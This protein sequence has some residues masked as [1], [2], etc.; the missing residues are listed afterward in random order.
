LEGSGRHRL[1]GEQG[2]DLGWLAALEDFEPC[3]FQPS[4]RGRVDDAAASDGLGRA[5]NET[6]ASR[7][8][9]RLLETQLGKPAGANEPGRDVGGSEMHLDRRRHRLELVQH[10]VEAI[11]D[12]V[13]TWLN[14]RVA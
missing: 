6:V 13:T 11:A 3:G 10:D 9:D 2:D 7:G 8:H 1:D 14:E 5:Q 12:R 4:R